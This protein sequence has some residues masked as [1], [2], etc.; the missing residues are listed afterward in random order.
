MA[1]PFVG[2][3]VSLVQVP[4]RKLLVAIVLLVAGIV[5]LGYDS[6]N[7][8]HGVAS[9]G[10]PTTQARVV[11]SEVE[12]RR[13]SRRT[14]FRYRAN[15]RY[16]FEVEGRPYSGETVRFGQGRYLLRSSAQ[17][18]V[19]RYPVGQTVD[20]S[21]SPGDPAMAT[22][23]PGPALDCLGRLLLFL[24]MVALGGWQLRER[25]RPRQRARSTHA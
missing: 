14:W 25:L 15:L 8:W 18:V 2:G 7:L 1:A 13:G 20:V 12:Y 24:A 23:T 4:H 6:G 3:A 16:R 17:E 21:Y 19:A 5:G 11:S 10:W 22:V 9:F